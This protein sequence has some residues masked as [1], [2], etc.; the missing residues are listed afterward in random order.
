MWDKAGQES[1]KLTFS[2][3][4]VVDIVN[5]GP[6]TNELNPLYSLTFPTNRQNPQRA[7]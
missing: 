7:D 1:S 6:I 5:N 4:A 2:G 3:A